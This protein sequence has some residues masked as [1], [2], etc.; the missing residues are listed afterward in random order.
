MEKKYNNGEIT[1]HWKPEMCI[2]SRICW[3]GL[4]S[5]FDPSK[6]PWI[7]LEGGS[8]EEIIAQVKKCPSGAISYTMNEE[9]KTESA[10]YE[11]CVAEMAPNGPLLVKGEIIVK[12]AQGNEVR[13]SNV[14]AFCRCGASSNKPYC[15][16]S[17]RNSGFT[18]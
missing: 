12:D 13:K 8:T 3:T 7:N 10:A 18:G 14:T 15:D 5:V 1:V 4:R 11:V 2:H 9:T 6:R 17:H 16:G